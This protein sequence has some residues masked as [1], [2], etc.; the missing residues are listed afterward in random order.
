MMFAW[1]LSTFAIAYGLGSIPFGLLLAKCVGVDVRTIG[2]GNIGA[3]NVMRT[4]HKGLAIATLVLDIAKGFMAIWLV[5]HIYMNDYVPIA[6]LFTVL[7][8]IFPVWLRFKGGKGV[9][10]SLGVLFALNI[11]LGLAVASLW[12]LV[13]S[14][15]RISSLSSLI[16]FGYSPLMA[17]LLDN[18]L[19][20]SICLNLAALVLFTHRAN[21]SRLLQGTE[22]SFRKRS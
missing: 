16:S 21:I 22:P 9:A 17:Y 15:S 5:R 1:I 19:T 7:G 6:G 13:F 10:T 8:H 14:F 4:G 3:T 18:Y 12:L 20:A 11:W 2:S